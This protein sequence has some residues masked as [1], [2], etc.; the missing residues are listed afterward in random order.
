M[1]D[2]LLERVPEFGNGKDV[3]AVVVVGTYLFAHLLNS[4]HRVQVRVITCMST[5]PFV[6]W[7]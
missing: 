3:F 7:W 5:L 4:L 2:A 1:S 6:L